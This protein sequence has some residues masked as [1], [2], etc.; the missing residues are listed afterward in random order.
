MRRLALALLAICGCDDAETAAPRDASSVD[1]TAIDMTVDT[2]RGDSGADAQRLDMQLD[3]GPD[4]RPPHD[5]GP[6][7]QAMDAAPL[8][9]GG[10]AALDM[11]PPGCMSTV[12]INDFEIFQFEASRVDATGESPGEDSTGVCSRAGVLPWTDVDLDAARAACATAGF[13]VCSGAQWQQACVG[14]ALWAYP[15]GPEYVAGTCNDHVAGSGA[16]EV[17]GARPEC[18]GPTGIHDQNGNVWELTDDGQR[19]GASYKLT[20]SMFR[21]EAGSCEAGF[22]VADGFFGRDIGFRC[23]RALDR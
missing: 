20:A 7:L 8:D 10:D 16:L 3:A 14:P 5:A 19:R 4:A 9:A 22:V 21:P 18:V 11:A 17:C 12:I 15:Y 23:C 1:M 6:D 2:G 13:S